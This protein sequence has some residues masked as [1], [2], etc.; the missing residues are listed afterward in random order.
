VWSVDILPFQVESSMHSSLPV[1]GGG[2]EGHSTR[3][4]VEQALHRRRQGCTYG[5]MRP[6]PT[7]RQ[8]S[9]SRIVW[10]NFGPQTHTCMV[11]RRS[12]IPSGIVNAVDADVGRGILVAVGGGAGTP[13]SQAELHVWAHASAANVLFRPR[14][15]LSHRRILRRKLTYDVQL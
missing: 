14:K 8:C 9:P 5:R 15:A 4:E 11:N 6:Q 2:T 10:Q 12:G 1:V 13:S 7:Y 3:W